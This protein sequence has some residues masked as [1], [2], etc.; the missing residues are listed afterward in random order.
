MK[1]L[2]T[3][4]SFILKFCMS[5]AGVV[6]LTAGIQGLYLFRIL[7][8]ENYVGT[9]SGM[10]LYVGL[11]V[12]DGFML[13]C[14]WGVAWHI[15]HKNVEQPIT[16]LAPIIRDI[17]VQHADLAVFFQETQCQEIRLLSQA[18]AHMLTRVKSLVQQLHNADLQILEASK[19]AFVASKN[20]SALL[21]SQVSSSDSMS[22]AI[23]ELVT[24]AQHIS[25]DVKAVVDVANQTLRITEQGQNSVMNV[26]ENM[27]EIQHSSKVSSNR[28]MA[29][30][31]QS[32]HISEVVTTIDRMIEDTKLIAFNAT[33]EAARTQ[34][35]GKGFGVVAHEIKLLAEE[36]FESTED[37]K[38]LIR[39]I[40]ESSHAL[41]L[42]T[43]EEVKTVSRGAQLAKEA[44]TSLQQIFDMVQ[45]T[46]ESAQRIAAATQQQKSA[47]E[48]V[49]QSVETANQ[50][51]SQFS[52]ESQQLAVKAAELNILAEGLGHILSGFG[53][54]PDNGQGVQ[55]ADG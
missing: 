33:I 28:I 23:R 40:Q 41:V 36:V 3:S 48:Q 20:Q 38:E 39:D 4:K 30:S 43:E 55:Q 31:K 24:V 37:I 53:L 15:Y 46:T 5:L 32:E 17:D 13:F 12:L 9:Q 25:D 22:E 21:V 35:E 54:T 10:V 47:R 50:S 6:L 18:T 1:P 42:A 34:D 27:E 8:R 51:S 2:L 52:K 29:L 11:L 14:L 16:L 7:Q 45:L 26:I 49:L 19:T 44:G